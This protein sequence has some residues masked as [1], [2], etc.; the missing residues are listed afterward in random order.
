MVVGWW[1]VAGGWLV[2]GGWLVGCW[3]LVGGWLVGWLVGWLAGWLVG[4]LV[5][6]LLVVGGFWLLV[7]SWLVVGRWWL[8]VG[9]VGWWLVVGGAGGGEEMTRRSGYSA[10]TK[11][12]HINAGQK[13]ARSMRST[14]NPAHK[15]HRTAPRSK[16]PTADAQC[17]C[18]CD[19]ALSM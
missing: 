18:V 16:R 19:V 14:S 12:P 2:V 9:G 11:T 1:L 15:V 17:V 5:G 8:V 3:L 4:W 13:L 7:G 6:W 10:K